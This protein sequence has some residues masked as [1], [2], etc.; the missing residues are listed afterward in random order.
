LRDLGVKEENMYSTIGSECLW[1]HVDEEDASLNHRKMELFDVEYRA[2][3]LDSRKNVCSTAASGIPF[4]VAHMKGLS[5]KLSF[6]TVWVS[7]TRGTRVTPFEA[8]GC[9]YGG[10][11]KIGHMTRLY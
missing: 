2:Q 1:I 6:S 8:T 11:E 9:L 5:S 4:P 10:N 3:K 7:G